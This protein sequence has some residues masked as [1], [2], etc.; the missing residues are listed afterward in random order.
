[1]LQE[2]HV[3]YSVRYYLR[4]YVTAVGLGT[5]Y[6]WIRGHTSTL[7]YSA[8]CEGIQWH[9]VSRLQWIWISKL[10]VSVTTFGFW[11]MND[12]SST[13]LTAVHFKTFDMNALFHQTSTAHETRCWF[14][15][16]TCFEHYYAHLQKY[17][18][19]YRFL[20]SKPGKMNSEVWS[21]GVVCVV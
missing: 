14:I 9:C 1:M 21:T 10:S 11:I 17:I 6:R 8:P 19:E 7:P 13:L 18:S 12:D 16:S 20:V 15:D 5:Y 4:F 2:Y 3:I